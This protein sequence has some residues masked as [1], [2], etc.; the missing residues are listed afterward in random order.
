MCCLLITQEAYC[1]VLVRY[2]EELSRPFDEAASFLSSIQTQLSNLCSGATS[3]PATTATHSGNQHIHYI[4]M[5]T[6]Q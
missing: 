6:L 5:H 4:C 2:K 1:R 3:P